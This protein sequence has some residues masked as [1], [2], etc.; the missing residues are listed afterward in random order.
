[1][2]GG[3][4]RQRVSEGKSPYITP[5]LRRNALVRR[6]PVRG[7]FGWSGKTRAEVYGREGGRRDVSQG[8]RVAVMEVFDEGAGVDVVVGLPRVGSVV[9]AF[10]F[11]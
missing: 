3:T 9:E 10:P 5:L 11:D 2:S 6:S 8:S 1:M 7:T 4:R